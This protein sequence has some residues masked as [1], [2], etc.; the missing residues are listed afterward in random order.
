MNQQENVYMIIA[1]LCA[2]FNGNDESVKDEED[3][4]ISSE[5]EKIARG[6][7]IFGLL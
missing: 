7:N 5:A 4:S 3:N 2:R 6:K 1:S